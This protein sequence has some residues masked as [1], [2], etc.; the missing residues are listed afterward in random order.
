[1][2]GCPDSDGDGVADK[3]DDCPEVAGDAANGCASDSDG[4][5]VNDDRDACP[6]VAGDVN[7]CPDSDGDGVVDKDDKCPNIGGVVGPDGCARSVPASAT[8]VFRRAISGINFNSGSD[9]IT[10][11]SYAI[12]DEVVS[13]MNQYPQLNVSIEGHTDSQGNDDKNLALSSERAQA[14]QAYLT[15]KGVSASRLRSVGYGETTPIATNDT[16]AGRAQN[17]RVELKGSY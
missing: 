16:S 7:G 5:G 11:E 14:V 2:R 4:D 6:N 3:D 1:M 8:E 15:G 9:V 12:L 10:N 13:V 17:R